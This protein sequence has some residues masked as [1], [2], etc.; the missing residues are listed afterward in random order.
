MAQATLVLSG[1]ATGIDRF[2]SE[3][4]EREATEMLDHMRIDNHALDTLRV[5]LEKDV[6][7]QSVADSLL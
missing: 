7:V 5:E 3:F 1:P 6:L 4:G 2:W